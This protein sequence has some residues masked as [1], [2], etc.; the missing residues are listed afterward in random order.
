[1]AGPQPGRP[2]SPDAAGNPQ[3]RRVSLGE[4]GAGPLYD[5]SG[6]VVG[7]AE[8]AARTPADVVSMAQGLGQL[9]S[10]PASRDAAR[11]NLADLLQ[12]VGR[13][14]QSAVAHP[15]QLARDVASGSRKLAQA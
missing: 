5:L 15:G 3:P 2:R 10:S 12:G 8:R 6:L 11:A 4:R 1:M 13:Y 7:G 9:V 14:A